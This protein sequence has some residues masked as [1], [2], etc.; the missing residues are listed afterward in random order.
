MQHQRV[1]SINK[2]ISFLTL[3]NTSIFISKNDINI[4]IPI[5]IT[6]WILKLSKDIF[7][8]IYAISLFNENK[9]LF[10]LLFLPPVLKYIFIS[11]FA[12]RRFKIN[13]RGNNPL[14]ILIIIILLIESFYELPIHFIFPVNKI[15]LHTNYYRIY[16][17]KKDMMTN[18]VI[19]CVEC[20]V[21]FVYLIYYFAFG[22]F[23][24]SAVVLIIIL[25]FNLFFFFEAFIYYK[26][27]IVSKELQKAKNERR[28]TT[29][30]QKQ[31]E[32]LK[33]QEVKIQEFR[34]E[35]QNSKA[36]INNIGI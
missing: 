20:S 8:W 9:I 26:Y 34:H 32:E 21:L 25:C 27:L 28:D 31:F 14:I 5:N 4:N 16:D 24:Y 29:S 11:I 18:I 7:K 17:M 15:Y 2:F 1:S 35:T 33:E 12:L 23:H 36:S 10:A 13:F 22:K 6:Y 30:S 3:I 19:E